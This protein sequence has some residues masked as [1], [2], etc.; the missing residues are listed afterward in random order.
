MQLRNPSVKS[1]RI[2]SYSGPYSFQ[3]QENRDQNNSECK[4]ILRSVEDELRFQTWICTTQ[5]ICIQNKT[6]VFSIT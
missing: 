5:I 4:H 1:V 2:R 3:M 6:Q